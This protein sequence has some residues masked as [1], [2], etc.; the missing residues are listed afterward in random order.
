MDPEYP[1]EHDWFLSA[2]PGPVA[3]DGSDDDVSE[4]DCRRCGSWVRTKSASAPWDT[5]PIILPGIDRMVVVN[6]R[7]AL[8]MRIHNS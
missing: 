2:S 6:C 3:L 8:L 5:C 7:E 4:W 1:K